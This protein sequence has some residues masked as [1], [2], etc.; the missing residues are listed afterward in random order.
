MNRKY[1]LQTVVKALFLCGKISVSSVERIAAMDYEALS[2]ALCY[3]AEPIFRF[4]T[5]NYQE[6]KCEYRSELLFPR[7]GTLIY[8]Q[9]VAS[10]SSLVTLERSRELWLLD[11]LTPAVV[12]KVEITDPSDRFTAIYRTMRTRNFDEISY[13]IDLDLD[14]LAAA[15]LEKSAA[16]DACEMPYQEL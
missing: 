7:Y 1:E 14:A 11:D 2:Q 10:D 6:E 15:L 13:E 4:R 5:D 9:P 8:E 16:F 12:S 3:E